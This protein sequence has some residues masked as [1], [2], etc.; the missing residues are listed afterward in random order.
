MLNQD[1]ISGSE[2]IPKSAIIIYANGNLNDS[3]YLENRD[4]EITK[5]GYQMMNGV[6]LKKETLKKIIKTIDVDETSTIH[7]D[8][9][10][11]KKL[12]SFTNG[13]ANESVV[14]FLKSSWQHLTFDK[15]L[16]IK[17]GQFLL[18]TLIFKLEGETLHVYAAKTDNVTAETKLFKAPFHN[19]FETGEVCMGNAEI[20]K[21]YEINEIMRAYEKAFFMSKF[22]H[23]QSQGSPIKGNINTYLNSTDRIEKKVLLPTKL[24]VED[25]I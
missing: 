15:K 12:L 18:P 16:G 7:C 24:K 25:L 10:F 21:S 1:K 6:P 5:D 20:E 13:Y 2:M 11:P 4:I 23:L 14:W 9:V 22:T 3:F 19:I 8:G 17:N